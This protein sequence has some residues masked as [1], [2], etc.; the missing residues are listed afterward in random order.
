MTVKTVALRSPTRADLLWYYPGDEISWG[1]L[2]DHFS[3]A[4]E[5]TDVSAFLDALPDHFKPATPARP[6]SGLPKNVWVGGPVSRVWPAILDVRARI[7][8]L[9]IDR[10]HDLRHL[11]TALAA[12]RCSNCGRRGVAPRP[13]LCPHAHQLCG[14][15]KLLPQIDWIID[16]RSRKNDLAS[17]V[18][19]AG[20]LYWP[21]E[22]PYVIR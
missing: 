4:I 11:N 20:A 8:F 17:R 22:I 12:W 9:T 21:E 1:D 3:Y 13:A 15:A 5:L 2:S 18:H 10:S 7:R 16:R 14:D 19:K 6:T